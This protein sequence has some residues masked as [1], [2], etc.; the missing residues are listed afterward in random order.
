M[1]TPI[2]HEF[3]L[4]AHRGGGFGLDNVTER[5]NPIQMSILRPESGINGNNNRWKQ[6]NFIEYYL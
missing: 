4:N 2:N 1:S 5:F 6:L 3:Y